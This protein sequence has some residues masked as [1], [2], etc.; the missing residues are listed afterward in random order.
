MQVAPR[1][2][3]EQLSRPQPNSRAGVRCGPGAKRGSGRCVCGRCPRCREQERWDRI[4]REKFE[5]PDY[6]APRTVRFPSSLAAL[7]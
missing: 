2:T 4:F 7:S 5:D 3:H 1:P 6:Y